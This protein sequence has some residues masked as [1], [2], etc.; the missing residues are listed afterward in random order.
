MSLSARRAERFLG[1]FL[2]NFL[3]FFKFFCVSKETESLVTCLTVAMR[4]QPPAPSEL[5]C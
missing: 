1:C 5:F 4:L 2:V 3:G